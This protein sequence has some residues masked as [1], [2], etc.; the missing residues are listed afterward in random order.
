MEGHTNVSN[1]PR[2]SAVQQT[3]S[4]LDDDTMVYIHVNHNDEVSS[5]RKTI[6][7]IH[8]NLLCNC[9][10]YFAA[11][12]KGGFKEAKTGTIILADEHP[13]VIS[14]FKT[15][16]YNNTFLNEPPTNHA[17]NWALNLFVFPE[18]HFIPHLQNAIIDKLIQLSRHGIGTVDLAA[19]VAR[20]WRTLSS[21]SPLRAFLVDTILEKG[22]LEREFA[23]DRWEQF[24]PD[25]L[26][27]VSLRAQQL[28]RNSSER[29]GG[30][31][32]KVS[33][34]RYH[35][36]EVADPPCPVARFHHPFL[37]G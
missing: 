24:P 18:E 7:P 31:F 14:R 10:S 28:S 4:K 21:H 37:V 19:H 25:F 22:D 13:E 32:R 5:I 12:L 27:A 11:A 6:F 33:C 3:R 16:L 2:G 23:E 9:S 8:K 1:V 34:E 20:T 30:D 17:W 15:W 36:H 29:F 26:A 35:V